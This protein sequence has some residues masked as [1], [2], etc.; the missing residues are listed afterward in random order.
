M[1]DSTR[2]LS[3]STDFL[4]G[5]SAF[6]GK[7]GVLSQVLGGFASWRVGIFTV[8]VERFTVQVGFFAVQVECFVIQVGCVGAQVELF[9]LKV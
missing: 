8:Q 5:N 4:A 1:A 2:I 6:K 3:S 7:D 9:A